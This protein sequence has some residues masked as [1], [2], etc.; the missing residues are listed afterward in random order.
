MERLRIRFALSHDVVAGRHRADAQCH[1]DAGC[2]TKTSLYEPN[3]P[4]MSANPM[5]GRYDRVWGA[6]QGEREGI[7]GMRLGLP[8]SICHGEFGELKAGMNWRVASRSI[9]FEVARPDRFRSKKTLEL[10]RTS[11]GW[12]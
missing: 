11:G 1:R 6:K 2:H 3:R 4:I 9:V 7:V 10:D 5:D 12:T 8:L